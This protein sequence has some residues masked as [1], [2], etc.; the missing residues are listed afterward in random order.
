MK[1]K[2]E[3]KEKLE[4]KEIFRG[5]KSMVSKTKHIKT[6]NIRFSNEKGKRDGTTTKK[7]GKRFQCRKYK[8]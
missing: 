3:K 2:S 4:K 7:M 8:L 6:R 5:S 1:G